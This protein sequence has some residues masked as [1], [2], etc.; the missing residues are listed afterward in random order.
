MIRSVPSPPGRLRRPASARCQG[1]VRIPAAA[2]ALC[3]APILLLFLPATS[4]QAVSLTFGDFAIHSGTDKQVN[5]VYRYDDVT[6]GVDALVSIDA[7]SPG[8]SIFTFD[9]PSDPSSEG[10]YEYFQPLIDGTASDGDY[11]DFTVTF[12]LADTTTTTTVSDFILAA[13]DVDGNNVAG[14][15]YEFL[16]MNEF[17]AYTI[18]NPTQV[19]A[20]ILSLSPVS[21]KFTSLLNGGPPGIT[22]DPLHAFE[23]DYTNISS[24]SFRLGLEGT[25]V[26]T[27]A[28]Q[29]ALNMFDTPITF[30]D[31]TTVPVPEPRGPILLAVAALAALSRRRS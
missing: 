13:H 2:V 8:A 26:T 23:L 15:T 6:T 18:D 30:V 12:V 28:R 3:L 31:P 21:V 24:F 9:D 20:N 19:D 25:R 4:A 14:D 16:V 11:A 27:Q 22:L 7:L 5:A 1:P 29:F 10:M 17:D